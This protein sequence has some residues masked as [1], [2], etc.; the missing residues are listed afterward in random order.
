MSPLELDR[1]EV[2]FAMGYRDTVPESE[3]RRIVDEVAEEIVPSAK[4]R[5]MH[6]IVPAAKTSPT[7]IL[8]DGLPFRPGG[9]ICSYLDGM[10]EACVFV[11]TAGKE[12][13]SALRKLNARGDIVADF[14]A[15]A[16]GTVLAEK[17]VADLEHSLIP[18]TEISLPYSPGYCGWDIREQQNFFKLFPP[19]PCG[20]ELSESSLMNPEKSISG[21]CAFGKTLK[22]QPYHCDICKNEKCYKRKTR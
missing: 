18:G 2:W 3:L 16:I 19:Q 11:A 5:H 4:P 12:F 8:L 15:D 1:K 17:A 14:V 20:I 7:T 6:R 9:I 10:T 13:D 21:F 22:R